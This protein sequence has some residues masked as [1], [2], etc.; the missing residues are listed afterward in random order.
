MIFGSGTSQVSDAELVTLVSQGDERAFAELLK[1]HQ[2]AVYGFARRLLKDP[3]EAEDASQ[4]TFLRL[5]RT[6]GRYRPEAS[7]RTYLLKIIKN[8]CIDHH[9]KKRP[10][11]MDK[12]PDTA[13]KDTPLDMLES[14]IVIDDLE[15]AIEILPVNQRTA[16]LLRH[17][18]QLS[19]KKISQVMDVSVG[20]VESLLVR[21]RRRLRE[22]LK[23]IDQ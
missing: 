2:D 5:Y 21:A 17:T 11:L 18:E 23:R 6:S 19:Y 10:E 12:L 3:Q 9:R 20:A 22:T 8:I 16:L 14:A 13:E 1:R 7:L 15:K 4:E